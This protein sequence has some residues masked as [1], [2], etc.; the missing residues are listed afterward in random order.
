M[1]GGE[2]KWVHGK[3]AADVEAGRIV[4]KVVDIYRL[5]IFTVDVLCND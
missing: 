2:G 1:S 4:H 5:R 3:C